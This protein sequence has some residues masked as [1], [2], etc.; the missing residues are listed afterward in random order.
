MK[1]NIIDDST[2]G[3]TLVSLVIHLC[4]SRFRMC[5]LEE[6]GAILPRR[7]AV[8]DAATSVADTL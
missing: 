4:H 8:V 7:S 6:Y 1:G 5:W 3:N 2:I